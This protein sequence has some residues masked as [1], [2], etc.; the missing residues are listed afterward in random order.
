MMSLLKL[1]DATRELPYALQD[2]ILN[3]ASYAEDSA[4]ELFESTGIPEPTVA[5]AGQLAYIA[6]LWRLWQAINSQ[7]SLLNNSVALIADQG[8]EGVR[9][10]SRLYRPGS[11][12]YGML[13][14]LRDELKRVLVSQD[15]GI[16]T[17]ARSLG[18]LAAYVAD[19]NGR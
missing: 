9:I 4:D 8:G 16:V 6:G 5:L 19:H 2:Q 14:N 10:G 12:E 3:Y 7:L 13:R 11:Y 18:E 17:A 15:L 1:R